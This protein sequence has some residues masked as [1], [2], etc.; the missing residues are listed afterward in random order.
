[1][2]SRDGQAEAE[3][4]DVATTLMARDYKG[5]NTYG[6][7]GAIDVNRVGGGIR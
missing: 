4:T 7:N 2:G 1:M 3:H 6:S 5:F